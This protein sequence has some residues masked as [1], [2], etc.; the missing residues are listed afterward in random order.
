MRTFGLPSLAMWLLIGFAVAAL[1][2]NLRYADGVDVVVLNILFLPW[3][4]GPA[5]AAARLVARSSSM[6]EA[7]LFLIVE[8]AAV[9]ST[10][11]LW[12]ELHRNPDAQNGIVM[13]LFP[14]YQFAAVFVL[15]LVV[16]LAVSVLTRARSTDR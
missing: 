12:I 5:A 1:A 7:W 13:I 4:V 8:V 16:K 11:W 15:Y 14:A 10:V 6:T 3:I 9:A 2:H